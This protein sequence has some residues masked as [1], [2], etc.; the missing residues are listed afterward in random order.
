VIAAS[1]LV[2]TVAAGL[3]VIRAI[4][5]PSLT[6][7]VVGIDG[8]IVAGMSLIMVNAVATGRGAFLPTAVVLALVSFVSTSIVARYIEGRE[9]QTD[10]GD[11]GDATH[12]VEVGDG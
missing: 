3:F 6:D 1:Y 9:D 12:G 8:A 11:D 5:G 7:R 2:L 10:D 4:T